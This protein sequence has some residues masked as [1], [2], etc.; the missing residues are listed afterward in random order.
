MLGV[1]KTKAATTPFAKAMPWISVSF[2]MCTHLGTVLPLGTL[3]YLL[4]V[5]NGNQG[6]TT[7][8]PTRSH[9]LSRNSIL[10]SPVPIAVLGTKYYIHQRVV[11]DGR[12]PKS[13]NTG[14]YWRI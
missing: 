5:F 9:N 11:T 10:R 14:N 12:T 6:F 7:F 4:P 3:G 1:G 8:K 2:Q 13:F